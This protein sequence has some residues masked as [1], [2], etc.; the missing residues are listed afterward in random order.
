MAY[1]SGIVFT[2]LTKT[3]GS[4]ILSGG[5]YDRL[6]EDFGKEIP[7]VGFAMGLKRILIALERQSAL[8]KIPAADI[9]LY[10][11][12]GAEDVAYAEYKKLTSQGKR[13]NLYCGNGEKAKEKARDCGAKLLKATREGV[14]EA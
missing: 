4:P 7:A 5:R 2:G 13:V 9:V 6:S 14:T 11:E 12:E 10:A 1:Y 3:L 8:K